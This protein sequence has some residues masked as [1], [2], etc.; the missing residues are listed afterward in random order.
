LQ[1]L[2]AKFKTIN[3]LVSSCFLYPTKANFLQ[4]QPVWR[5]SIQADKNKHPQASVYIGKHPQV[6]IK[7]TQGALEKMKE[8]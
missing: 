5:V 4:V 6:R 7:E 1:Q 3:L 2:A 8:H